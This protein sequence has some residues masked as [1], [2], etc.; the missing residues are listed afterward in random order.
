MK[1]AELVE[2]LQWCLPYLGLRW[3]GLRKVRNQ[4]GKRLRR[5]LCD[6]DLADLVGYRAYLASHPDE[7]PHLDAMCRI[8]ISRFYR[9]R[10]VFE[11]ISSL[12]LP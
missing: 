3:Q 6:L 4:V 2:F 10:V 11:A 12:V 1:R 5:R 7:W 9:D 8:T